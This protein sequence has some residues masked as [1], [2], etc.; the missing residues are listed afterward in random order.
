MRIEFQLTPG[1]EAPAEMNFFFPDF[2]ALCTAENTSHTLHNILT[3][4]GAQVRD[5]SNWAAYLTETIGLWGDRL[6]VVFASHHWPT[7]GRERAVAYLSM[8][9]DMYAYLHDQT[10]RM[11]NQGLV[12]TEIAEQMEMPPALAQQWHTHGYYGSVSHN[13]KAIYQRY[14]GWY[15][16]NPAHL[17]THPPVEAARRYVDAMG[18]A[19]AATAVAAAGVRR[20]RLPMGHRGAQPR[21]LRRRAPRR[22][23]RASRPT[24]WSSSGSGR[25]TAPGATCTCRART[26][27]ATGP[28]VPRPPPTRPTSSSALSVEQVVAAIAVRIDGPKAWDEHLVIS[29]VVTDLDEVHVTEL[30]HGVLTRRLATAPV[31]GETTFTLTRPVLVGALTGVIDVVQAIGDGTIGVDGDPMVLARLRDLTARPDPGFAIVTP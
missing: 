8:Q 25:R 7:W 10:L 2:A 29:W 23:P 22:G 24:R 11:M 30:R 18:G 21:A 1:T 20:R 13:V 19:D 4:R 28:S 9:R 16:G 27:C 17:W 26:S 31:A 6:D 15:D 12:G 14:L 3:L 5:A